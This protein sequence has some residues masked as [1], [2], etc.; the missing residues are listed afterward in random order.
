[1]RDES[2]LVVFSGNTIIMSFTVY[3]IRSDEK[4]T[5]GWCFSA[6]CVWNEYTMSERGIFYKSCET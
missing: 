6:L 3:Q 5:V 4:T 2:I 1:M